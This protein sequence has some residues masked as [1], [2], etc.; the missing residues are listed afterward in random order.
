[1]IRDLV[2]YGSRSEYTRALLL[3]IGS[4]LYDSDSYADDSPCL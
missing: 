1:M 2:G 4:I 3:E